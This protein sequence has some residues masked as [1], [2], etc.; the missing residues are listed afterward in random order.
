MS[1]PARVVF[2]GC[3]KDVDLIGP[4]VEAAAETVALQREF[5]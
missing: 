3:Q 4:V 5:W 2:D 1:V